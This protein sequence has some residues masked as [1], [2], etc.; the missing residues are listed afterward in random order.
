MAVAPAGCY[1]GVA[2]GRDRGSPYGGE[3]ESGTGIQGFAGFP[4][5]TAAG[6]RV[7]IGAAIGQTTIGEDPEGHTPK[8]TWV[9]IE[10]RYLQRLLPDLAVAPVVGLGGLVGDSTDGDMLGARALVGAE[11]RSV[12]VTFGAGLMPQVIR[13]DGESSI[14]SLHLGLWVSRATGSDRARAGSVDRTAR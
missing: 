5:D 6:G 12:P 1:G 9:A 3:T 10:I 13:S 11:T 4:I 7:G 14:R 8:T 2:V